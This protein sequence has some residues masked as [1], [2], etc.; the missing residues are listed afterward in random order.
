M[1][2]T[3][4][5]GDPSAPRCPGLPLYERVSVPTPLRRAHPDRSRLQAASV[6]RSW[7]HQNLVVSFQNS[8]GAQK[9]PQNIASKS[10][11]DGVKLIPF[12]KNLGLGAGIGRRMR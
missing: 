11:L 9:A 1:Q 7:L 2:Q 3:L 8:C 12:P 5:S 10:R 6:P 4:G